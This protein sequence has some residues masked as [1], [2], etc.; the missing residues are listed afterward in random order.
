MMF[1]FPFGGIL[2]RILKGD[3]HTHQMSNGPHVNSVIRWD[4]PTEDHPFMHTNK[5]PNFCKMNV[6]FWSDFALK[7]VAFILSFCSLKEI[8]KQHIKVR[9][10]NKN[11]DFPTYTT[12]KNSTIEPPQKKTGALSYIRK[13]IHFKIYVDMYIML[14][15]FIQSNRHVSV[16]TYKF[17]GGFWKAP[18]SSPSSSSSSPPPP[19]TTTTTTTITKVQE[20]VKTIGRRR[21]CCW[22]RRRHR[23]HVLRPSTI[24]TVAPDCWGWGFWTLRKGAVLT[25]LEMWWRSRGDFF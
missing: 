2:V 11:N 1:L 24:S 3:G 23:R 5:I 20:L 17:L 10:N 14:P 15:L 7:L 18:S 8:P 12:E 6:N 25:V 21:W 9:A 13:H 22:C 19:A 16:T 4:A